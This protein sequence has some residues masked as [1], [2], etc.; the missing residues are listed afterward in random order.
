MNALVEGLARRLMLANEGLPTGGSIGD[1]ICNRGD[2]LAATGVPAEDQTNPRDGRRDRPH[3]SRQAG[4]PRGPPGQQT[5][6]TLDACRTFLGR[7][8]LS[9][10]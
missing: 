7:S 10:A 8:R 2:G 3:D 1:E 5:L 9:P 6:A 4:H